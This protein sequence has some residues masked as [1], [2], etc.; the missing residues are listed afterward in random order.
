MLCFT[1]A[2]QWKYISVLD[3]LEQEKER[4]LWF[5]E[6]VHNS[7]NSK[8]WWVA[9]Q[10]KSDWKVKRWVKRRMWIC[11]GMKHRWCP[12]NLSFCDY[13]NEAGDSGIQEVLG[14]EIKKKKQ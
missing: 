14:K 9:M 2:D 3:N 4:I 5:K 11:A 7:K 6:L 13:E 1:I 12:V 10:E 8:G